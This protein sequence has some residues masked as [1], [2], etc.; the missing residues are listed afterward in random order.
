MRPII[1]RTGH[2][3]Q[4]DVRQL[5]AP[6]R[7][8]LTAAVLILALLAGCVEWL[9]PVFP[10]LFNPLPTIPAE[11]Q[12]TETPTQELTL[13]PEPQPTIGGAV[14]LTLWLPPQFDP[15]ADTPAGQ[16]L[17]QRLDAFMEENPGVLIHVR[18]KAPSGPGGLLESLTAAA[19]AAPAA[20]PSVIALNRGD[21]EAAA[22]KGLIFPLEGVSEEIE[23]PDWYPYAL[24]MSR[25]QDIPFAL[26]I[27]GDA[28]MLFYR[29]A[30]VGGNPPQNW[31]EVLAFGNPLLFAGDD[32]QAMFTLTLYRSL[33][34]LVQDL[35]G[36]PA[37]QPDLLQQ[38][39]DLYQEGTRRG[40]F[41]PAVTQYQSGGQV[42]QA[43][44][45]GQAD[46]AVTFASF[47]LTDRPA[48]TAALL[49]PSLGGD[50]FTQATG[51]GLAIAD[52]DPQRRQ[53]A[54]A[55]AEYLSEA[56]FLAEWAVA[57]GY[58]PVHPTSITGWHPVTLQSTLS[59]VVLSAQIRPSNEILASLGPVL[60]EGTLA[61]L[62]NQAS[63]AQAAQSAAEKLLAP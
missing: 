50:D 20:L 12:P 45:D 15:A 22:L 18:I 51:W 11:P 49:L 31:Q 33:G 16:L 21:L 14:T 46:W 54:V 3:R 5:F 41:P 8:R 55:L 2:N 9:E 30:S 52:P 10:G 58:L 44:L 1:P 57:A 59:R 36:R 25:V 40:A 26:P 13:T 19:A 34:G 7:M 23:S 32:P 61:V 35:Q 53:L 63:P 4:G 17:Q 6:A 62:R 48:D 29:P 60:R 42:W 28:L 56:D 47:Y 38:V 37:L 39:F 27:A 43:Y 24:Q